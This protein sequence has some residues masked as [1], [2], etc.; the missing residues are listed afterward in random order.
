[1]IDL[2]G[3]SFAEVQPALL[4]FGGIQRPTMGGPSQQLNRLGTRFAF[5]LALPPMASLNGWTGKIVAAKQ[6]GAL[7]RVPEPGRAP[8]TEGAPSVYAGVS[9]G[10]VVPMTG[11]TQGLLVPAGKW[12]SIIHGGRRYVHLVTANAIMEGGAVNLVVTPMLRTSL[13]AGDLIEIAA[14]KAQGLLVDKLSWAVPKSRLISF[15]L[16]LEEQK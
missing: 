14:P 11:A 12:I 13:A 2:T 9:G 1:M 16:S 15:T 10:T 6:E 4:E 3:L 5:A 8:I 7:I